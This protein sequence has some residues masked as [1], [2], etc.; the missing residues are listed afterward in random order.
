MLVLSPDAC[1]ACQ[2]VEQR[3]LCSGSGNFFCAGAV[4]SSS[5]F[6]TAAATGVPGKTAAFI[7]I[8][9]SS[10]NNS[11]CTDDISYVLQQQ[12]HRPSTTA[13]VPTSVTHFI[14]SKQLH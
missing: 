2:Q 13:G 7:A 10:K 6:V 3:N 1:A 12:I 8:A 4:K 14:F 11:S 9:E 5:S